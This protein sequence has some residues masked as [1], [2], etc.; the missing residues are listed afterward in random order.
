MATDNL[1]VALLVIVVIGVS[2]GRAEAQG[3]MAS[4][5]PSYR[6]LALKF[7]WVGTEP[8]TTT[9]YTEFGPVEATIERAGGLGLNL[10]YALHPNFALFAAAD[11]S[12]YGDL[13][14]YTIVAAGAECRLPLTNRL[15]ASLAGGIGRYSSSNNMIFTVG[16]FDGVFEFFVSRR[17]AVNA[18]LQVMRALGDR[19][20]EPGRVP[21]DGSLPTKA[22]L[23]SK[24]KRRRVGLSWY[25]GKRA[26]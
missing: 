11:L 8:W 15:A 19:V 14:G 12:I 1:I 25:L 13:S 5:K 3:S 18:G 23:D 7:Q 9:D 21:P 16:G 24:L 22:T 4:G 2:P 10:S 6:G 26:G 20:H 17:L